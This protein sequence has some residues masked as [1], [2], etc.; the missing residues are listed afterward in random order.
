MA[1]ILK[2]N[3]CYKDQYKAAV[4]RANFNQKVYVSSCIAHHQN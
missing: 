1:Y 3:C 2:A 4:T